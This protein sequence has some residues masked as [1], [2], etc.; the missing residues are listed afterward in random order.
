MVS[1]GPL[2]SELIEVHMLNIHSFP[3]PSNLTSMKW[4][5]KQK[6]NS[7]HF[8]TPSP[9]PV[10]WQRQLGLEKPPEPQNPIVLS[11]PTGLLAPLWGQIGQTSESPAKAACLSLSP[12]EG[13]LGFWGSTPSHRPRPAGNVCWSSTG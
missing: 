10:S 7:F 12:T 11:S 8:L 1:R 3:P 4:F 2:I 6:T 9:R 5:K 13:N